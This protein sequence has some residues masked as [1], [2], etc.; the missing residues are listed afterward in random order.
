M[1]RQAEPD[2]S[3]ERAVMSARRSWNPTTTAENNTFQPASACQWGTS[4]PQDCSAQGSVKVTAS[5]RA[6]ARAQP[7]SSHAKA[8]PFPWP[9]GSSARLTS[10]PGKGTGTSL[11]LRR[12]EQSGLPTFL[13]PPGSWTLAVVFTRSAMGKQAVGP[14]GWPF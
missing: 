10:S 14:F 5:G 12:C 6:E 9:S 13:W 8:G 1:E 4:V 2:C 7:R 11:K 3:T